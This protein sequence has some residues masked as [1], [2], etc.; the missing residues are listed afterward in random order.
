M[1]GLRNG[2]VRKNLIQN[3]EPQRYSWDTQN[4]K[5]EDEEEEEEKW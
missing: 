3:D 2:H 1:V 5:K 4:K